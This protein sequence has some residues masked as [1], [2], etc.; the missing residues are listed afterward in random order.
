LIEVKVL[1]QGRLAAQLW[2]FAGQEWVPVSRH[3]PALLW[4]NGNKIMNPLRAL[5]VAAL[6]LALI[7]AQA[8]G[9]FGGGSP[10]IWSPVP[11]LLVVPAFMGVPALLVLFVFVATFCSWS[12]ALFR[13]EPSTPRRTIVLYVVCGISSVASF[14]VGWRSGIEYEGLT[15]TVTCA[16]LSAAWFSVCSLFLWRAYASP[17]FLRS[18]IAQVTL[19][20]WIGSYAVVYL[21]ETP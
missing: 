21:G 3:S 16:V 12:P 1:A 5:T 14:V 10:S 15:Y 13:G 7:V 18:L 4:R 19:F 17:T 8:L 9:L 11:F 6:F 20:A 2:A